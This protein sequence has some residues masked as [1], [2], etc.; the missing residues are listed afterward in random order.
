[1]ALRGLAGG[2]AGAAAY[3]VYRDSDGGILTTDG[4]VAHLYEAL[5]RTGSKIGPQEV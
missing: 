1:M 4:V 2:A 3:S 5:T